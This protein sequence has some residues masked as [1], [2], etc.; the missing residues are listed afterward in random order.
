MNEIVLKEG[1][2]H[3]VILSIPNTL[4]LVGYQAS[5]QVRNR[6]SSPVDFEFKTID[7]TLIISGQTIIL[8]I[9]SGI[10]KGK[11][12][13]YHWQLKIWTNESDAIVFDAFDFTIVPSINV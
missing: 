4:P 8:N 6:P 5:I 3:S 11:A 7:N 13:K 2:S 12:D 9:P 1:N 10:T